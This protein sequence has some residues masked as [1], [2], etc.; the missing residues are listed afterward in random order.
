MKNGH[1]IIVNLRAESPSTLVIEYADSNVFRVDLLPTLENHQSLAKLKDW[2]VFKTAE[3]INAGRT[4]QWAK[5][6]E[7]ELAADSLRAR[8]VEQTGQ[9]SHEW[10]WN[11]MDKHDLTLDK[12]AE[13]LGISRR[14]LV[15]Y[16]SGAKPLPRAVALACF[17]W[18]S[19]QPP[20]N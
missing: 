5:D 15:Y 14:V 18:E 20:T 9:F 3:V 13:A 4:V 6:D 12:A 8:A 19:Q 17:G 11:W 1:F 2:K 10:L 7:L 16:R